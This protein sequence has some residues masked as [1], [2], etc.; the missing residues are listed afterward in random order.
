MAFIWPLL[1]AVDR[2]KAS[3][4]LCCNVDEVL[5]NGMCEKSSDDYPGIMR[6]N[7]TEERDEIVRIYED[8]CGY[9]WT[10]SL[11]L[12]DYNVFEN[13]SI[14]AEE[15]SGNG[16]LDYGS[17]CLF[18]KPNSSNYSAKV[19]YSWLGNVYWNSFCLIVAIIVLLAIF[20]GYS[21]VPEL[22]NLH[23]RMLRSY[24]ASYI[25]TC[26]WGLVAVITAET[27]DQTNIFIISCNSK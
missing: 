7:E 18:R 8:P 3:V 23:G 1:S 20:I 6:S 16:I 19:C 13:G 15:L 21:I 2:S 12:E 10:T 24:L 9:R 26:A 17:Y 5:T 25:L 4:T 14:W 11:V 27:E 22:R